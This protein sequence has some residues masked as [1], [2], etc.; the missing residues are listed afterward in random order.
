MGR[1]YDNAVSRPPGVGTRGDCPT[2]PKGGTDF[3]GRGGAWYAILEAGDDKN[4][5]AT[6]SLSLYG[7]YS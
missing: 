2:Q 6:H 7:D 5:Y 3:L 4:D 1:A